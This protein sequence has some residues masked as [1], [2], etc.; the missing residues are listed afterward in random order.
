M[1]TTPTRTNQAYWL[2]A[3]VLLSVLALSVSTWTVVHPQRATP[4][5]ALAALHVEE[6]VARDS[7]SAPWTAMAF[8][9]LLVARLEAAP[10]LQVQRA[11][12]PAS[13]EAALVLH[14]ELGENGG[15]IVITASIRRRGESVPVW[16]STFWRATTA[17]RSAATDV[18]AAAAEAVLGDVAK[19]AVTNSPR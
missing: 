3:A 7:L 11:I 1:T 15:R 6:V 14:T 4:G 8:G 5:G 10:G 13:K 19:R 9:Q 16:T 12:S 2:G 17:M 18:A